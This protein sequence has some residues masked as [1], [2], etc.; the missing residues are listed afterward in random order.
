MVL[1]RALLPREE[2]RNPKPP[3][4]YTHADSS[5][6]ALLLLLLALKE[7]FP[8]FQSSAPEHF[9]SLAS[10]KHPQLP[11]GIIANK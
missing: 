9:S 11:Q 2:G 8:A 5:H 10:S 6:Q 1:M 3:A 7:A 4:S